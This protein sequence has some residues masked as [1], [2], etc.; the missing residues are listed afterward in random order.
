MLAAGCL[1]PTLPLPPPSPPDIARVGEGR[2]QLRG[3][4]PVR[5]TVIIVNT[6]TNVVPWRVRTSRST[7]VSGECTSPATR[8]WSGSRSRQ[9]GPAKRSRSRSIATRACPTPVF[10]VP[11][12][13]QSPPEDAGADWTLQGTVWNVRRPSDARWIRPDGERARFGAT[14]WSS[15]SSIHVAEEV[16][17]GRAGDRH[18]AHLAGTD[19]AASKGRLRQ[20][21]SGACPAWRPMN[22]EL[23]LF[24]RSL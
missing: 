1:S 7:I 23:A 10:L 12:P 21:I 18:P 19:L 11:T 2:Y 8:C 16:I 15:S 20:S 22:D 6:R 4:I 17:V 5:G 9:R 3:S 24:A 14:G 13:T